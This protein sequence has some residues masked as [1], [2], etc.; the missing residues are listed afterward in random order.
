MIAGHMLLALTILASNY[1]LLLAAGG[2]KVFSVIT[3][4]AAI[5]VTAFEIFV[6][7][8][9]AYVFAVL[10]AVYVDQSVHAH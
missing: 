3:F 1:F 10:T 8:L 7:F 5:A 4:V 2:M 9:Q 6:A